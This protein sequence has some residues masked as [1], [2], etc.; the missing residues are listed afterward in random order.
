MMAWTAAT[1]LTTTPALV[2][3]TASDAFA[4][5]SYV[6]LGD[7]Y[8]AGPLIPDQLPNPAGCLR[9]DRNYPHVAASALG[10]ALTDVSCSGATTVDMTSAQSVTF[11]SNPPQLGA[12][13]PST[14]VVS[15]GIGGNDINFAGIIQNCVAASP[16][17]PTKV[18][19]T[20]HGHYV[21]NGVDQIASAINATAPKVAAVLQRIHLLA[22]N[23]KVLVVGYPSI[24]PP[25]GSGC[26]PQMPLVNSDVG[27]LRAKQLSLNSMLK[28]VAL[29]N[30]SVYID[31]YGPS[32]SHSA[33]ASEST[34]WVEPIV[35]S[36]WA[37]PV[38]PN[39]TGE[40]A[41]ATILEGALRS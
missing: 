5:Q 29:A 4:S 28:T 26:W 37:A 2:G 38:H 39:A 27:Y 25:T 10:L 35:P 33:C 40:A 12:V 41:M 15:I 32:V 36:A 7:S 24:L 21:T 22:P 6:S 20:C 9:S 19:W 17:G 1:L 13:T 31:T 8:T 30:K 23:A 14:S 3:I 18:G 16:W 11:G 34:R